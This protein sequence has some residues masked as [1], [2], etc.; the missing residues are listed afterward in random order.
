MPT[1]LLPVD[2]S[3]VTRA[4]VAAAADLAHDVE[5]RI[6][7]LHVVPPSEI[8]GTDLLPL[9]GEVIHVSA[10]AEREARRRLQRI[11]AQLSKANLPVELSCERGEAVPAI[12]ACAKRIGARYIVLGSHG[13][14]ALYDLV[15]G[16]TTHG[17]LKKA[18]CPVVVVPVHALS[19]KRGSRSVGPEASVGLCQPTHGSLTP[20]L[21]RK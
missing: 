11:K 7:L 21:A 4:I 18:S 8:V 13:H 19:A 12:L 10:E 3:E 17:V 15:V 20:A 6:Y 16:S 1:I 9:A 5:G 2:F 14:T